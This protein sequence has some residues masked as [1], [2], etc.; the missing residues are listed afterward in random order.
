[1]AIR[2][3]TMD[4]T[5]SLLFAFFINAAI[6][7]VAAATFHGR[8]MQDVADIRDAYQLL[9]PILGVSL[10]STVFAVALWRRDRTRRSPAPWPARS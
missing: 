1:M 2:F 3:A 6:L 5:I 7:M 8:D 10:A 9:S 4:S